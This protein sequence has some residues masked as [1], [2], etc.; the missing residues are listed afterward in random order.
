MYNDDRSMVAKPYAIVICYITLHACSFSLFDAFFMFAQIL[1]LLRCIGNSNPIQYHTEPNA[2]VAITT[3]S[4]TNGR[5]T[6]NRTWIGKKGNCFLT[7]AIPSDNLKIPPTLLP[8]QI[9]VI[10]A[11]QVQ[12]ML[13]GNGIRNGIRNGNAKKNTNKNTNK[14]KDRALV[15]LKW[16]NDVLVNEHKIAG[17]LIESEKDHD[18]NYYFLVGIGV[19]YRHAP[20]VDTEGNNRGRVTTCIHDLLSNDAKADMEDGG[21]GCEDDESSSD[22]GVEEAK[23]LGIRIAAAI[24][25][26]IEVQKSWDGTGAADSIVLNWERWS[27]DFGA[28]LILRDEPGNETVI[29]LGLEKDGRLR[30]VGQDGKERLLCSDYLL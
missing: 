15:R 5:G 4:Q 9:G 28:R 17:V 6:N 18:G 7:V 21:A 30:V 14:N 20:K 13:A 8:L 26:W 1:F 29:T 24:K 19:N 3:E 22:D 2:Y 25:A 12:S 27:A 10:L 16:P 11:E 23:A